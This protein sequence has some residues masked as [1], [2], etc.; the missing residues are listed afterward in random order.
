MENSKNRRWIIPF[1]K[2]S[3]LR[4]NVVNITFDAVNVILDEKLFFLVSLVSGNTF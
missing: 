4:V 2:F 3:R 1:K